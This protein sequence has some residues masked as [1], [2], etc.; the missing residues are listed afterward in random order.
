MVSKLECFDM[1]LF[2]GTGDL[3]KRKLL[4]AL[5]N[6][7]V[8]GN[9]ESSSRF[10]CLGRG[11]M[12]SEDYIT[13]AHKYATDAK[14]KIDPH[15]WSE[16]IKLINYVQLDVN[17]EAG[18]SKLGSVLDQSKTNIYYLSTA[19]ELFKTI[20][21]N[22][23]K[24]GLN[25]ER[26]RVVLEKPLG[27]DLAS[28]NDI[29]DYV[30]QYFKE[31]Q[32]YRIDHFLG[33]ESVQNLMAV[34]FGNTLFEALWRRQWVNSVQITVSEDIGVGSRGD[35]YEHT[36][37]LR[38][39]LQNH[40]L[41]MLCI[42][43]MEPPSSLDADVIR[44][45][46]LKVLRSLKPLSE[47]DVLKNVIKGQ[48]KAGAVAGQSVKGYLEEEKVAPNSITET[49]VALKA[50]IQN[51]RWAGVPFYLRTGKRMQ[52]KVAEIVIQFKDIPCKIFPTSGG[53]FANRLIIRI[54]PEE[55]V[56]LFFLAK[57]PGDTN[58]LQPV[59]LDL[60]F[61]EMFHARRT[62][63]YERLLLDIIRGNLSL[64]VRRDEQI[65]AWKWVEPILETWK[66]LKVAPK[67][68]PAGTWGPASSSALLARD[69]LYWHEEIA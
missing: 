61:N 51:W 10:F 49:F 33:K 45:E 40:L 16:F 58:R 9:I 32:I 28:S 66:E 3:V 65:A 64:F 24:S 7:F 15:H 69:G 27:N 63:G 12:S 2:G 68:Y 18:Y 60:D 19:P 26:S 14:N 17:D 62:D 39:M 46:K 6:A 54:Q 23:A 25:H 4:P 38:D 21:H 13:S 31:D 55:T 50:E 1:V 37:A 35:F 48:Y 22:L 30:A 57:Q 47:D 52:E 53:T 59:Y 43:A 56:K 20:S 34:R 11:D 41:Q 67:Q 5:Y 44:D 29:N 36:G 42:V 8:D